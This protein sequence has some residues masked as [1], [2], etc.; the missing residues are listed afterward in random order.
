MLFDDASVT[1]NSAVLASCLFRLLNHLIIAMASIPLLCKICPRQP[2]FSDQSHLLTHVS[3]KGHLSHYFKG[4]VCGRQDANVRQR[5]QEYDEWYERYNIAQ[6]LAQRMAS[7]GTRKENRSDH[8]KTKSM[9]NK[10]RQRKKR[11]DPPHSPSPLPDL[12]TPKIEDPLDPQ[13]SQSSMKHMNRSEQAFAPSHFAMVPAEGAYIAHMSDWQND[14]GSISHPD[15]DTRAYQAHEST[16]QSSAQDVD[17]DLSY[18][19][20]LLQSPSFKTRLDA[21]A[22][23][24]D[25][26]SRGNQGEDSSP[27]GDLNGRKPKPR[28]RKEEGSDLYKS[29]VLKGIKWPG[30]SLFD[31]ADTDAQRQRNQKKESFILQQMESNSVAVEPMERIYWPEGT[32][33]KA[34]VITGNVESSPI[35]EPSPVFKR[36][37]EFDNGTLTASC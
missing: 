15:S 36:R 12:S 32:L 18:F 3:S 23:A 5:V 33:K 35:S 6:L 25:E 16:F 17:G 1:L 24:S 19:R 27:C 9:K 10:P 20:M 8:N 31:S 37:R 30:M 26:T 13:L 14:A 22:E 34:R 21:K 29:P 11:V 7:K 2:E 4:Q 28:T